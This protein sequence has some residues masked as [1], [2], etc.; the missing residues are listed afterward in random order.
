MS[1][2]ILPGGISSGL[3]ASDEAQDRSL[4]MSTIH[5]YAAVARESAD[6][7]EIAKL[8]VPDGFVQ[9]Q[10]GRKVRPNEL[11][12]LT[13]ANEPKL[14]RHHITTVDVQFA[15]PGEVNCQTYVIAGTDVKFPDHWGRWD[16]V[17]R[18]QSD[19]RW[20]FASK[21]LVTDGIAPE[22]WLARTLELQA[23]AAAQ[24]K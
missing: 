22:G 18:K 3:R 4:I 8:F 19:G 1:S 2:K 9:L 10:D 16:S 20:L 11:G 12:Q 24:E 15:S 5:R 21:T 14:L 17:L 23:A 7:D 6:H 13:R